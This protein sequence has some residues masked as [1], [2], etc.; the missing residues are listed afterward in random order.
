[1][2]DEPKSN[3]RSI[4]GGN[5]WPDGVPSAIREF[6]EAELRDADRLILVSVRR[7]GRGAAVIRAFCDRRTNTDVSWLEMLGALHKKL[8][9]WTAGLGDG[10]V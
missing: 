2:S 6:V 8:H 7:S 9:D 4:E 1:M 5:D 3:L 10:D